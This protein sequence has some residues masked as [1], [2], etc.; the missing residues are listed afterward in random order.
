[1]KLHILPGDSIVEDFTGTGV[2][3][4]IIVF[5]ECLVVGDVGGDDL[6]AFWDARSN[7]LELEYGA[8]PIDYR[9]SVAYELE[10]LLSLN[11]TDEVNLWFEHDV[12]CQVNMW[13]CID[14]LKKTDASIFRVAPLAAKDDAHWSGFSD[15]SS[16]KLID[17]FASRSKFN[18]EDIL[19][20]AS[21]WNA[22][23]DRDSEK[24]FAGGEYE[25]P[26][27][28]YL[29]EICAAAA[30]VDEAPAKIVEELK[31]LGFLD[32]DTL[33]PE[34]KKRAGIYGFGNLQVEDLMRKT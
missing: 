2:E 1:M 15:H 18:G 27:F 5:R 17:C 33:F 6:D 11:E 21:L 32:I 20:G 12:F 29:Q 23:K 34:F 26:C 14:L 7:F 24:L 28:P 13:F 4:D 25:S 22:F 30:E 8:D 31:M 3:G 9:E 16:Q 10:R 19:A